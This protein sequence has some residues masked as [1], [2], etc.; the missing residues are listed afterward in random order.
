MA[1]GVASVEHADR[2][3]NAH[4][5]FR[6]RHRRFWGAGRGWPTPCTKRASWIKAQRVFE[7]AESMQAKHEPV[8]TR[9]DSVPGFRY[10][11]LLLSEAERGA[12]L[13]CGSAFWQ[14]ENA[15]PSL[16]S[17]SPIWRPCVRVWSERRICSSE[18]KERTGP[19]TSASIT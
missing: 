4:G 8:H 6:K 1:A 16:N 14:K 2:G 9:L 19:S 5:L 7:E 17:G 15:S 10:C 3:S 13:A 18:W 11:D 12:P